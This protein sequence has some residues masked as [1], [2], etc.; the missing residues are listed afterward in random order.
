MKK[1][2]R[3]TLV[4]F[5]L[6]AAQLVHAQRVA[7]YFGDYSAGVAPSVQWAKATH[8]V[9]AFL[10]PMNTTGAVSNAT[11][12]WFNNTNFT[13][14]VNSARAGNPSIKVIISVGGAPGSDDIT[15]RLNAI[16]AS[17]TARAL[18]Q[19]NL[20]TFIQNNNLDGMDL[21]LEHPMSAAEKNNH[22]LFLSEM[23]TK[24]N[25]LEL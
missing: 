6:L 19:N 1:T 15:T 2:A 13:N 18:L 16:F 25:A 4:L 24:L 5:M 11:T 9:Y 10:N 20:I 14:T 22:E 8:L 17:G 7:L 12:V 21:D 3:L 23:K